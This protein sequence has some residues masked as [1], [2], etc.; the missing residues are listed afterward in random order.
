MFDLR[1]PR[2]LY[3]PAVAA[4]AA[5]VSVT[6][7]GC[8]GSANQVSSSTA[9]TAAQAATAAPASQVS[10]TAAQLHN[11]LLPRINGAK[12]AAAVETGPYGSLPEVQDTR[13][14]MKGVSISPAKCAQ[15]TVA[16]FNSADFAHAPASMATFRIGNNGVSEVL[17]APSATQ[18]ATALG[19]QLTVGCDSYRATVDG[20]T[21]TY[22]IRESSLHGLGQQA[23]E[24]NIKAAGYAQVDV[25]SVLYRG[26][27]FVGAVTVVGPNAS[28]AVVQ[29]LA[30]DAYARAESMLPQH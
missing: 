19:R 9:S 10:Y 5:A 20:K 27:G 16:G 2:K 7:T 22:T 23:R 4:A 8:G 12:P 18:A 17:I 1:S 26:N 15:A 28:Q 29:V 13:Q 30:K 24:L 21:F 14:S 11:A 3:L 25:W 6:V